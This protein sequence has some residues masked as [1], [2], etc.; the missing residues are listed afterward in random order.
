[1]CTTQLHRYIIIVQSSLSLISITKLQHSNNV[2]HCSL[3]IFDLDSIM[4]DVLLNSIPQYY[5]YGNTH[6]H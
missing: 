6:P 4:S 3:H 5:N 1:M 2:Q